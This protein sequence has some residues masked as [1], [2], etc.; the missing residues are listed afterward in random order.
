[1]RAALDGR[2]SALVVP[3]KPRSKTRPSL[4]DGTWSDSY[5]L[6]PGNAE[7]LAQDIPLP[8]QRLPR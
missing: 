4:L 6:D 8:R 2:L 1:V 3:I 7:W 5:V